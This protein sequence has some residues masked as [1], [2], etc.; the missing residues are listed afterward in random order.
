MNH[1][2]TTADIVTLDQQPSHVDSALG[3]KFS[4]FKAYTAGCLEQLGGRVLE[5]DSLLGSQQVRSMEICIEEKH[6]YPVDHFYNTF[7]II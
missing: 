7:N 2:Y 6:S 5:Q 1:I 4:G 3:V